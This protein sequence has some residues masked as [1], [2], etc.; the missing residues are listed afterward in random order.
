MLAMMCL[1]RTAVQKIDAIRVFTRHVCFVSDM[2][3]GA[4]IVVRGITAATQ[5]HGTHISK[6]HVA[7]V[8]RLLL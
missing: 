1:S 8:R 5:T 3:T 7:V 4:R 6:L 2:C